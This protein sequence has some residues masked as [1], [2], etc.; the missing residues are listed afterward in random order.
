[1]TRDGLT[2]DELAALAG[3]PADTV[4]QCVAIGLFDDGW[5]LSR[6]PPRFHAWTPSLLTRTRQLLDQVENGKMTMEYFH[7]VLWTVARGGPDRLVEYLSPPSNRT[8]Q[9][10]LAGRST[11]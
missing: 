5:L 11:Q 2:V 3:V 6:D 7:R 8:V 10:M 9:A 4:D 1:M